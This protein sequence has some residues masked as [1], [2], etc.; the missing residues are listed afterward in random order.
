MVLENPILQLK[1]IL[2]GNVAPIWLI[3]MALFPV[4]VEESSIELAPVT[5]HRLQFFP[6]TPLLLDQWHN[7]TRLWPSALVL[8][9]SN[10]ETS[11]GIFLT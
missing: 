1:A 10:I 9:R 11:F 4:G 3:L 6:D 2:D 7:I 8:L 5:C